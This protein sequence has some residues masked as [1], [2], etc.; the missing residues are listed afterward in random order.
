[1]VGQLNKTKGITCATPDGAFYVYPD[2]SAVIGKT[3][4]GGRVLNA[5]LDVANALLEEAHVAV[6]PGAAF[7]ASPF[8]R[9]SYA[10]DMR[11]LE[12]ACDRMRVFFEKIK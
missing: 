4:A 6:V 1:M 7:H 11:S 8:F 9:I 10:T 2:C 12:I 5:D 3:S